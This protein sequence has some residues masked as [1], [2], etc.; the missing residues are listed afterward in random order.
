MTTRTST[1]HGKF[2]PAPK[3]MPPAQRSHWNATVRS[4]P[5]DWFRAADLPILT[6]MVRAH[7]MAD[8]LAGRIAK[9]KDLAELKTLLQL[10]DAESRRAASLATKLRLPPQSRSDRHLAGAAARFVSGTSKPWD[11]TSRFFDDDIMDDDDD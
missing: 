8:E 3:S 11:K 4:F 5:S 10:R 7:T 2:P 9:T 1:N 6:E